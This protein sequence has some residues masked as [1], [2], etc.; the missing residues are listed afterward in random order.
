MII[1]YILIIAVV[2]FMIYKIY[3]WVSDAILF[4]RLNNQIN[5]FCDE[6]KSDLKKEI[7]KLADIY[8][9]Q[10]SDSDFEYIMSATSSE[11]AVIRFYKN[12]TPN[13]NIYEFRKKIIASASMITSDFPLSKKII[14]N[15][16][17]S[18]ESIINN[19]DVEDKNDIIKMQNEQLP[20]GA[21]YMENKPNYENIALAL[22]MEVA[23]ETDCKEL[24]NIVEKAMY[25]NGY[26][27]RTEKFDKSISSSKSFNPLCENDSNKKH[28][29]IKLSDLLAKCDNIITNAYKHS[30]SVT[31]PKCNDIIIHEMK[32]RNLPD[33]LD[34]EDYNPNKF[35]IQFVVQTSIE[36]ISSGK[37]H[38][39]YGQLSNVGNSLL[40]VYNFCNQFLF[41]NGYIS[42]EELKSSKEYA[43]HNISIVG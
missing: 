28:T 7:Q 8:M 23:C 31:L 11:N 2:A 39:Y 6:S 26:Y 14:S 22:L 12:I 33:E 36:M 10:L 5:K 1:V 34:L 41:D 15:S 30:D 9:V 3:E 35:A 32:N 38:I 19:I 21:W 4:K 42:E 25:D 24:R 43:E 18:L 20:E 17:D 27:L 13:P 16:L 29:Y 37:Y 40:Y